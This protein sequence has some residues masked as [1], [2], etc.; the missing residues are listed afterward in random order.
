MKNS[1]KSTILLLGCLSS[2]PLWAQGEFEQESYWI[3]TQS[4]ELENYYINEIDGD[5]LVVDNGDRDVKVPI[6]KIELIAMSPKPGVLGQIIG[7]GIGGY[8]G[9]VVGAI[10]GSC[11]W[12]MIGG[13]TGPGGP[14]GSIVLGTAL[15]GVGAGIYYGSKFGGNLLKGRPEIIADMTMWTL[16]EK[17]EWIHG[18][19]IE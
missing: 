14:G 13:T 11:I 16:D 5:N 8:C 18:N 10:P 6:T 7:G 3:Y 2:L 1:I 15:V 12:I 9:G 4:Y 19:L 17:K